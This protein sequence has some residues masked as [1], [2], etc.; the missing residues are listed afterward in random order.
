MELFKYYNID[1]CLN[2]KNVF[3]KLDSLKKDGK[4]TYN[5]EGELLKIEDIDLEEKDIKTLE[6][7]FDDNDVYPYHDL[8]SDDEDGFDFDDEDENDDY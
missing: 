6:K 3:E 7:V 8:N 5:I 1:E 2:T 4:I